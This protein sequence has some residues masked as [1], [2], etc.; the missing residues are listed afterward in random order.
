VIPNPWVLLGIVLAWLASLGAVGY[1][2]NNAGHVAESAAWLQKDN[3]ELAAANKKILDLEEAARKKES[4][5][6]AAVAALGLDYAE[7]LKA[8]QDQKDADVRAALTGGFKL[9]VPNSCPQQPRLGGTG[10]PSPAPAGGADPGTSE[11]PR[12]VTADLLALADDAD[13]IVAKLAACQTYIL[14]LP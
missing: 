13:R 5:H 8:A 10:A 12:A 6:Q 14:S 7:K 3:Q 4:D 2:Q 1:W 11:L 9:R